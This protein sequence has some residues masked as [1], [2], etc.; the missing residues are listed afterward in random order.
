MLDSCSEE[1]RRKQELCSRG[2]EAGKPADP[3]ERSWVL[4]GEEK[5]SVTGSQDL[6][7]KYE[8]V[9]KEAK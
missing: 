6:L 1:H 5:K 7:D 8:K 9:T 4:E 3:P 2:A